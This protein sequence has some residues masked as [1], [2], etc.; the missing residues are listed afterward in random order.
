MYSR[1]KLSVGA[2][3]FHSGKKCFI[4]FGKGKRMMVKMANTE[5]YT[6][7]QAYLIMAHKDDMTFRTLL[8][9]LDDP[10]NDIFIHMD[11]KTDGYNSSEI[12][13]LLK[14]SSVIHVD[15]IN[16]TWGGTSQIYCE[17][18]LLKEAI[19][20]G[21]HQFYHLLS[22]SDLPI[23]SQNEIIC[24]FTDNYGKEFIRFEKP[25]YSYI[26]RTKFYYPL[27]ERIGRT[28]NLGLKCIGTILKYIQMFF[29]VHRN[30]GIEFQKGTSWFSITDEFARY[31]V[32]KESWIRSAFKNTFCCDEVFLQTILINSPYKDNLYHT[33]FDNDPHAI[34]RLIDWRRG[35]PYT[36]RSADKE[37]LFTSDMMFARKFDSEIDQDIIKEISDRFS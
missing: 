21:N 16:V 26:D 14:H 33:K 3:N 35:T 19:N 6:D 4:C 8:R 2:C 11:K 32:E 20:N 37:E 31:V 9:M 17:L 24:F 5:N 30:Q 13:K 10:R 1:A 36:F 29:H 34:M 15:R 23:K 28:Q 22:G 25:E 12:E 7:K 27:Q 18:N